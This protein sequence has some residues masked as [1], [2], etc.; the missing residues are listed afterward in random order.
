MYGVGMAKEIEKRTKGL[1][2]PSPGSLYPALNQLSERGYVSAKAIGGKKEYEITKKGQE[3][4]SQHFDSKK[5]QEHIQAMRTLLEGFVDKGE[6]ISHFGDKSIVVLYDMERT[7]VNLKRREKAMLKASLKR[8]REK[9]T[10]IE[11]KLE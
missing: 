2:R 9:M 5:V 7:I 3:I 11:A 6:M 1:W 8:I 10:A 4:L